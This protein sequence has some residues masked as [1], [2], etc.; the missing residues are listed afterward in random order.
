MMRRL[1]GMFVLIMIG[2]AA[3][4]ETTGQG[5]VTSATVERGGQLIPLRPEML[6]EKPVNLTIPDVRQ[7]TVANGIRL[8]VNESH[9]LPSVHFT[10]LLR[11]G[12]LLEPSEKLG[13]AALTAKTLRSGGTEKRNGDEVDLA[14]EQ[15]G[16]ELEV[17]VEREYVQLSMFA[18]AEKRQEAVNL[19]SEILLHPVFDEKKLAQQKELALEEIRREND[20]P[21]D[22]GRREFRKVVYGSTHPMARSPRPHHVAGISRD[23]VRAFYEA[24]YRPA[25]VWIG[26]S[27]DIKAD[28]AQKLVEA[29]F[30]GWTKPAAE[31]PPPQ[32]IDEKREQTSGVFV[33]RR[34]TA[35]TQIRVGH[36]GIA[37]HVPEQYSVNVLNNV[38]GM[39]GFSSRLMLEVRTRRGYAYGVG[40]GVFSDVGKGLFSAAASTKAKS[41]VAAIETILN[42]AAELATR[43]ISDEELETAKRDLIYSFIT[44]FDTPREVVLQY[45][46]CDLQGYP[47]DYLKTYVERIRSVGKQDVLDAAK[48]YIHPDRIKILVVGDETAFDKPLSS[49]GK[50]EE[51]RLEATEPE[52]TH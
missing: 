35:Q 49:L 24:Y 28:E 31:I 48:R 21:S 26:V 1:I 18:L 32:A 20:Q 14:L 41:T 45:L 29:A 12:K 47:N 52:T 8:F 10:V 15:I 3:H 4:S 30:G 23:D 2:V 36:L 17:G 37:R 33:I 50:V 42:V 34:P 6:P 11:A 38:F 43:E 39:G 27:G 44:Q 16:S 46:M 13:V 7:T 19:L 22:T 51:V 25:S 5:G 40:G 9:D